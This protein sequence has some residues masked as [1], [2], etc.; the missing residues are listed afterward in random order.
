MVKKEINLKLSEIGEGS[1]QQRFEAAMAKVIENI[2]DRN[3]E[4]TKKRSIMIQIDFTPDEYREIAGMEMQVK[5]KLVPQKATST[6]MLL[7]QD[8][9]TGDIFANELHSGARG[10]TRMNFD[11]GEP[12][13]DTG[14]PVSKVEQTDEPQENI[15]QEDGTTVIDF[16]KSQS[17]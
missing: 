17:N 7:S 8:F 10:Q 15:E 16:R 9:E 4:D 1:L 13:T 11:K 6:R 5:E 2:Q 12:E 3:T 14:E